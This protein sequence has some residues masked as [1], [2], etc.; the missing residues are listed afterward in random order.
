MAAR[1]PPR[2]H[3]TRGSHHP[4]P[5]TAPTRGSGGQYI[6]LDLGSGPDDPQHSP[7]HRDSESGDL[8]GTPDVQTKPNQPHPSQDFLASPLSEPYAPTLIWRPAIPSPPTS[9]GAC[10]P[11]GWCY[12]Q[13]R[14]TWLWWA[15]PAGGHTPRPPQTA[16]MLGS[17][18]TDSHV[19]VRA[20]NPGR[21]WVF[22]PVETL[23]PAQLPWV[24]PSHLCR[25]TPPR[26][27]QPTA[28]PERGQDDVRLWVTN[29]PR[30]PSEPASHRLKMSLPSA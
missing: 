16:L 6:K 4:L 10:T 13:Q 11:S 28:A 23:S 15:R 2:V 14:C 3:W 26:P 5:L 21:L 8:W 24:A 7:P 12:F 18:Q 29:A 9:W 17:P 19:G 22:C 27:Q 20:G 25:Q 30:V 1:C